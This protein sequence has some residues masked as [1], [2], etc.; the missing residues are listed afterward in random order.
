VSDHY[1]LITIGGGSAARDGAR[2]AKNEFD[3]KIALVESTRWGGDCPNVA[4]KPT[5]AYLVAAELAHD[6][7]S[8]AERLGIEVGDAH[9]NLARVHAFKESLRKPQ[10][11]WVDELQEAG[12]HPIDGTASFVD[13][14]TLQVG[15]AELTADRILIATGSRTAIPPIDGL[16]DVGYLDHVS[17]LDLTELPESLLVVGAGAVGLEFAQ[18]FSRFGSRIVVVD[19]LDRI[20]FRNDADAAAALAGAFEEEQIEVVT[21]VFVKAVARD[22]DQVRATIVPRDGGSEREERVAQIL[23]AAGRVPNVERLGLDRAG[24]HYEKNGIVVD[25]HQRTN[26][27]GIWAAGDVVADGPQLTPIAQYQARI[28]VEDMFGA[29]GR[30]A[31]YSALPTA[32]FTDP[33]LASVGLAEHEAADNGLEYDVVAQPLGVTRAQ[34]RGEKHGLF[35]ILFERSSRRVLGIHVVA[36]GA[37]DIVQGLGLAMHLGATVDDLAFMHHAYPTYA[38]GVKAAAEKA[39]RAPVRA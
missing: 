15:D 28:A 25:E 35:K 12:L 6:V 23:I 34:Y 27:P 16:D 39:G 5:K 19:A 21:D 31:D 1:D 33:E 24:V 36:R 9:A 22:G 18:M 13:A 26:V 30:T 37:S 38:E 17:A 8:Y 10:D 2:K 7:N 4:C 20:A 14:H 29:S 11:K 3:A 32:I